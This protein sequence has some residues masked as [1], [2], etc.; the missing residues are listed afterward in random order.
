MKKEINKSI[1][2]NEIKYN[3]NDNV[4]DL[5]YYLARKAF[6]NILYSDSIAVK[7]MI[8]N[9]KKKSIEESIY[10]FNQIEKLI[11]NKIDCESDKKE[12]EY[13]LNCYLKLIPFS[14]H[15]MDYNIFNSIKELNEEKGRITSL[16][17]IDNNFKILLGVIKNLKEIHPLDYIINSL[18]CNIIQLQEDNDEKNYIEK[19]VDYTCKFKIKNIF[20]INESINDIY[21]NP[22]N[23][24]KKYIFYYGARV[25]NLLNILS[26]GV[27]ILS[28]QEKNLEKDY[29]NGIYLGYTYSD[30][31]KYCQDNIAYGNN[32]DIEEEKN[33]KKFIVLVEAALGENTI[34]YIQDEN[35]LDNKDFY[36]TKD[37]FRIFIFDY[38]SSKIGSI[39]VKNPMNIRVKYI[40]E[41]E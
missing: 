7:E 31:I 16:Y 11:T 29:E 26:G 38:F 14:I 13:L 22:N 27:K 28:T 32:M 12:K 40:I 8:K 4:R 2:K 41:L 39:V 23:F 5:I 1:I 9:F 30:S 6:N 15:K 18:G 25:E 21:F 17:Y 20:K 35:F 36:T 19:Y 37:G 10:I 34:D 24:E 33:E 3:K